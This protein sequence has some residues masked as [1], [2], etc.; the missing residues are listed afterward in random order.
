MYR[1]K[2]PANPKHK[3]HAIIKLLK[4]S[5]EKKIVRATRE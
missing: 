2:K 3:K 4:I 1:S 5:N